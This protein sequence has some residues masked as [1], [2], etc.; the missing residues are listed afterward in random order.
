MRGFRWTLALLLLLA[1]M[2]GTGQ[3]APQAVAAPQA[4]QV[5]DT[6]HGAMAAVDAAT[7]VKCAMCAANDMAKPACLPICITAQV[8]LPEG[9]ALPGDVAEALLS[10]PGDE[11][12]SGSI[13]RPDPHPPKLT[14]LV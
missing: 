3:Y 2:L 14:V 11:R 4:G 9:I 1:F 13:V 6:M 12:V 10:L 5:A 8:I 7:P